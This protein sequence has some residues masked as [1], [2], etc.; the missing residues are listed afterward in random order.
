[1]LGLLG[2]F[3]KRPAASA[4]KLPREAALAGPLEFRLPCLFCVFS[5]ITPP[6]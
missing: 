4:L 2:L 6:T 3:S 1:M 5:Y